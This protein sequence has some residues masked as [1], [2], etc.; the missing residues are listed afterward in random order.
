MLGSLCYNVTVKNAEIETFV[1]ISIS[2]LDTFQF[3]E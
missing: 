1:W 2:N 3:K